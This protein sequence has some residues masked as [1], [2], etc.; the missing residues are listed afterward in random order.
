VLALVAWLVPD[1]AERVF[2]GAG[3]TKL[4]NWRIIG[5]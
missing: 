1:A 5:A 4:T 3:L 2:W